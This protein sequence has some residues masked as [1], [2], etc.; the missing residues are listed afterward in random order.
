MKHNLREERRMEDNY[1]VNENSTGH[2]NKE[3][4]R[5]DIQ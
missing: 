1:Y 4:K 2:H 5:D 3:I